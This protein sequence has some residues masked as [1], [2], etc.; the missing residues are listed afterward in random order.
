MLQNAAMTTQ[1]NDQDLLKSSYFYELP[2]ELIADRPVGGRHFSK[3]F[4]Y[5][6]KSNQIIH[7]TFK[8]LPMFLDAKT[9]L[10]LNQ[11]RVFPCR[12]RGKKT[13]G[14]AVE[15]FVLSLIDQNNIYPAMI[16]TSG[17]KSLGDTFNFDKLVCE[18]VDRCQDGTFLVKF[19]LAKKELINFLEHKAKT[20]IPP[21][22]RG[23]ESDEKDLTDYQTVYAQELGSVA[24]P[25]AGLHFTEDVF[26]NLQDKGI[27]K[28]FVT[29]HVGAGTFLPVKVDNILEHHMHCEN[30]KVDYETLVKLNQHKE[31]IVAVG[32]TTLRVL[33]SI[34]KNDQFDCDENLQ[35]TN[36]FLYPGKDV[37]SIKGLITNFHLPEST[38]LML[39]SSLVG[40]EKALELYK[41]AVE[42]KYRFFSYGD[43]MLILRNA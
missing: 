1:Q 42:N 15:V 5:K 16:K 10:V 20:P 29:L 34:Y 7:A 12:L 8:D 4:V 2:P 17:K 6:V 26:K 36:I 18:I 30:F 40:R 9:H 41:I 19:N 3:L 27:D 11:S 43:S 14:G 38:L 23:G 22:I 28:S 21:Y 25:T 32:T 37:K 31:N 13:T 39:V 35:S 33:E 24:A